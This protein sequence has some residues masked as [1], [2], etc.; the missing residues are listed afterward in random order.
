MTYS[1][2]APARTGAA[3]EKLNRILLGVC[4]AVWLAV[5]GTAV[6]AI[7]AL[8]EL[9]RSRPAVSSDGDTPWLLY[10]VIGVSAV[11][12]IG[13]VPLLL[14]ARRTAQSEPASVVLTRE[15][16]TP[17]SEP[18]TEKM[19]AVST[20][21]Q[22]VP[23]RLSPG[24]PGGAIDRLWLQC[25]LVLGIAMGVANIAIGAATYLMAVGNDTISWVLYGVAAVVT[26]AM[27]VAPWW[28]LR[29]LRALLEPSV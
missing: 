17:A 14:R 10:T 22:P 1:D 9:G 27:P 2:T 25:A 16:A 23:S 12:I 6:A 3:A 24:E 20:V 19:R 15:R 5:L 26:L 8:A 7:V 21:A 4:A 28:Y 18:A 11:V 29:E 13:A